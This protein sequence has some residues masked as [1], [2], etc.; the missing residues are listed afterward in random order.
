MTSPFVLEAYKRYDTGA[1][2]KE[3]RDWLNAEGVTNTLGKPVTYN[4]V[5]RMLKN[6]R[7][8]GEYVY[9][10]V[11]IPDGIPA[12]VPQD[13]F[14]RVQ[15]KLEQNKRAP[16]RHKAEDDYLL[17]TKLFCGYCGALLFGECG[18]GRS[19]ITHHYYKCASVKRKSKECSCRAFR[20]QWLEDLVVT[21]A[22]DMLSDDRV[23]D[24]IVSMV[25]VLQDQ[26]NTSLPLL[27]RQL[28]EADSAIENL[29]NAIQQGI[30]TRSTK[31]RLE[32]LEASR[33]N[34]EAQIALEKMAKPRITEAQVRYF[35]KHF[36]KL[37]MAK[38]EHRKIL[39]GIFLNAVYIYNDHMD[40]TFNYKEGTKTINFSDM[41]CALSRRASSPGS[42]LEF[43]PV[44]FRVFITDLGYEHSNFLY[45][46]VYSVSFYVRSGL[47]AC[48]FCLC[49]DGAAKILHAHALP[50]VD[51]VILREHI[52]RE[53]DIPHETVMDH[54]TLGTVFARAL[55][56]IHVDSV[57]QL[58]EKRR[59]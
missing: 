48:S 36:R 28:Q 8:I 12:I 21:E 50:G 24:A 27:E 11:V 9:K 19:G 4:S 59:G 15:Q 17:T 44:P 46:S 51:S 49:G 45:P 55:G 30:L 42:D 2:M 18:T 20:K 33:D 7:Y 32:E 38:L 3:I 52:V 43:S 1:T 41:E 13:L 58:S 54:H 39:V 5:E 53:D 25:M 10:D 14:D 57:D 16:A 23:I 37:D 56:L 6:R 35:L 29:L 40:I 26:E 22:T 34:L 47:D 31:T